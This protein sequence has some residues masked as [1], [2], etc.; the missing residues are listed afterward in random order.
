[1]KK[2]D[3]IF[4][5]DFCMVL[6]DK[7]E[8]HGIRNGQRVYIIGHRALPVSERDPYTQRIKF[9]AHR[10]DNKEVCFDKGVFIFDPSSLRKVKVNE[11]RNLKENL[12]LSIAQME[13]EAGATI[14]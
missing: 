12:D 13:I 2:R 3:Y 10:V 4:E 5:G 8:E 6:G 14:N 11:Q 1:M 9:F 7:F